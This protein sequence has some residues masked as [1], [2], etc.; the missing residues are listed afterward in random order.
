[1]RNR[2]EI[3]YKVYVNEVARPLGKNPLSFVQF[4]KR[5]ELLEDIYRNGKFYVGQKTTGLGV[6][7]DLGFLL[8][9]LRPYALL[10]ICEHECSWSSALEPREDVIRKYFSYLINS[11]L[12]IEAGLQTQV[13]I[14][15][16]LCHTG[17]G[18]YNPELVAQVLG[19]EINLVRATLQSY[20]FYHPDSYRLFGY[21][22]PPSNNA[23]IYFEI[24]RFRFGKIESVICLCDIN[25]IDISYIRAMAIATYLFALTIIEGGFAARAIIRVPN[26]DTLVNVLET[27]VYVQPDG[28]I[29]EYLK[30]ERQV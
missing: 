8:F 2:N 12:M 7:I 11:R 13:H 9:G 17:L 24:D 28:E 20:N 16:I 3:I 15:P 21:P 23:N 30:D 5:I 22:Q 14:G 1:M 6:S 29:K 4:S 25:I 26:K 18:I 27:T 19:I 10:G